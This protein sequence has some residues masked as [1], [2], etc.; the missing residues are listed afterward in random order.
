MKE[1]PSGSAVR[2][3]SQATASPGYGAICTAELA[4]EIGTI[5]RF[6]GEASL[7]LY[8]GSRTQRRARTSPS[9]SRRLTTMAFDRSSLRQLGIGP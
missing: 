5:A 6:R 4:G 7:A 8:L 3:R 1:G 2:G 9:V